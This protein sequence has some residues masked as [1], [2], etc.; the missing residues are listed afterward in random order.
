MQ[1]LD[2]AYLAGL[3]DGEGHIGVRWIQ[4]NGTWRLEA[5]LGVYSSY[6]PVLEWCAEITGVGIVRPHTNSSALTRLPMYRWQ[7]RRADHLLQILRPLYFHL[8][9]KQNLADVV[10]EMVE[11]YIGP[12]LQPGVSTVTQRQTRVQRVAAG[13]TI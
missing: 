9:I 12:Q 5:A 13:S 10:I 6:L 3:V 11:S 1:E 7:V 2:L 8:K 4:V